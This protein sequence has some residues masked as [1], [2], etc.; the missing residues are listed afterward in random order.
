VVEST[1]SCYV[2]YV[3]TRSSAIKKPLVVTSRCCVLFVI[4]GC[5]PNWELSGGFPTEF[6]QQYQDGIACPALTCAGST[7][8]LCSMRRSET[9]DR[10]P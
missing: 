3:S 10:I 4:L 6:F 2:R 7:A 9:L 8:T 1:V 5:T